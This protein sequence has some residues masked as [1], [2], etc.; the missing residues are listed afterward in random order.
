MAGMGRS[1]VAISVSDDERRTLEQW[2]RAP[3]MPQRLVRRAQIVLRAAAGESSAA[4]TAAGLGSRPTVSL[5]RA[6]FSEQ[7]VAGLQDV[8]KP[9]R[10]RRIDEQQVSR[11][12]ARTMTRP[13]G[14]THWSTRALARDQGISQSTASRLLR[15]HGLKPHRVETFKFSAD[16][17]LAAK[18]VDV[19]GLYLHPPEGALVLS[20]DEKTQIQALDH[21]QPLLP[22]RPGQVERHTHDYKRHGTTSLFAALNVAT[23]QVLGQ[24]HARHRHQEFLLFL[25]AIDRAYPEGE[26][27]LVLD[28]YA[29]HKHPA[30]W[31][32]LAKRRRYRL[33]F[34][35]T[36]AS[37]MNQVE[38][39]FGILQGQA[40]ERG[41]FVSVTALTAAIHAFL[42]HWNGGASPFQW[43][44]TADE[45]LAKAIRKP[46]STSDSGH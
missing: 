31:R 12:L 5:W 27:H 37:W 28:N 30:V 40:L 8:P 15:R 23:G 6:R 33:H 21:T 44:K 26:L 42:A 39:W 2:V 13:K 46:K 11:F 29:T 41:T 18:V 43:V 10:P 36:S 45:I 25:R 1:G 7:G 14:R 19:V 17:E 4:M 9:G 16:P 24:C 20:V 38:T 32:W 34:T 22:L 3:T 35:P